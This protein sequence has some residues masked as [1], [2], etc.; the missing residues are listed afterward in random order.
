M[1]RTKSKTAGR[2]DEV[3]PGSKEDHQHLLTLRVP[4]S[5][6]SLRLATP[7]IQM[8][9]NTNLGKPLPHSSSPG[10]KKQTTR[11]SPGQKRWR[12]KNGCS[13]LAFVA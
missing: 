13:S 2:K 5:M 10:K 8:P 6:G 7:H 3:S 12:D 9:L 11:T 1:P 4:A